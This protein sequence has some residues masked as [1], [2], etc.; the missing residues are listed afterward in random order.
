MTYPLVEQGVEALAVPTA[1]HLA[2]RPPPSINQS[3]V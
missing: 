1:I 3:N 2:Q